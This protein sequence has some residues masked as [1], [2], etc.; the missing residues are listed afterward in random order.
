MPS[1]SPSFAS[2]RIGSSLLGN[3]RSYWQ[4]RTLLS[5][6]RPNVVIGLGGFASAPPVL[7]ARRARVPIVLLE[8]NVVPG[9][10][11]CWL[12]RFADVV[13]LPW[14][15]SARGL[16]SRTKTIV[17]GN[18]LRREIAEL[19]RDPDAERA[20]PMTL[21]I[22]GGS[23]GATTLNSLV[24]DAIASLR[25]ELA[26][27][28]ITHQTGAADVAVIQQRYGTLALAADVQPFFRDM[29][30]QYRRA[31]GVLSRAGATTLSELACAG[32]PTVLVPLPTSAHDHQ[33]HNAKLFAD[34]DA[35]LLVE[36]TADAAST[37][38]SLRTNLFQL[39]T[40]PIRRA[41]LHR[42]M[43]TMARPEAASAV[44]DAVIATL[45]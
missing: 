9:K 24:L 11:T 36:Q 42:A 10:A 34:R 18:P 12:S 33:R 27:W 15:E 16:S 3:W 35:A 37:A 44:V 32:M 40:D 2:L 19:A 17:T 31:S 25:T 43:R 7:A 14:D 22:L 21:L 41:S 28:R 30:E 20:S 13:C 38:L 29:A 26:N 4:A 1:V 5:R 45:E 23:Q 39:L 8:Q 6:E